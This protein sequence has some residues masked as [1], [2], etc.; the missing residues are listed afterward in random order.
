MS[1]YDEYDYGYT[2]D[3]ELSEYSYDSKSNKNRLKKA[4]AEL[5][6]QDKRFHQI[7]CR[8]SN[9]KFKNIP[10]FSSGSQGC[11]I[12]NAITGEYYKHEVGS[13]NEDLYFKI[14]I[15]TGENGLKEPLTLFYE[16][17]QQYER[18]MFCEI[19]TEIKNNWMNKNLNMRIK[20]EKANKQ[21]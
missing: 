8:L 10:C 20:N 12:R 11:R 13:E 15:A 19:N 3:E 16:T 17:P 1:Y 5:N 9:G 6:K 18:H 21:I 4:M 14:I 2:N 7:K